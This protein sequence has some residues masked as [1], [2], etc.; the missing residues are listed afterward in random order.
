MARYINAA[1][2]S[3]AP[4]APHIAFHTVRAGIGEIQPSVMERREAEILTFEDENRMAT[5]ASIAAAA[6]QHCFLEDTDDADFKSR[7]NALLHELTRIQ[8]SHCAS[9][10]VP[11]SATALRPKVRAAKAVR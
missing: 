11:R 3:L 8:Q 7:L 4:G 10:D 6:F 9:G 5:L 2:K 1:A